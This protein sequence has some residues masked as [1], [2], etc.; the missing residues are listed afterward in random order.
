MLQDE[1]VVVSEKT[2]PH[3]RQRTN[4]RVQFAPTSSESENSLVYAE[5][6]EKQ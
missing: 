3:M 2:P 1:S 4:K 5:D 6:V